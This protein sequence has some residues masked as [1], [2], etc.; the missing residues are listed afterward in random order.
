MIKKTLNIFF[1][2]VDNVSRKLKINTNQRPQNLS[3]TIYFQLC[4]EYE[5]LLN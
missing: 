3:P 2:D 4:K 5:N 1:K